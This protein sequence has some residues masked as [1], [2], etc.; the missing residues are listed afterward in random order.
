MCNSGTS[1]IGRSLKDGSQKEKKKI[2][3]KERLRCASDG[4]RT[5]TISCKIDKRCDLIYINSMHLC[6]HI[7]IYIN[8]MHLCKHI[9]I[10]R[11]T[12][13]SQISHEENSIQPQFHVGK[14]GKKE[15]DHSNAD[16][17]EGDVLFGHI[18]ATVR[19]LTACENSNQQSP[20][21]V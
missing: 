12:A 16:I 9:L 11:A 6:K 4:G 7:R 18:F 17:L 5:L 8:S 2:G 10:V 21:N 3:W 15:N 20:R 13:N 14:N 1:W 19:K